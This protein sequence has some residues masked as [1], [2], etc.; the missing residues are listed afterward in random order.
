MIDFYHTFL[1]S[2]QPTTCPKCAART[3]FYNAI[4]PVSNDIVQV[5]ICFSPTCTFEFV[6]ELDHEFENQTDEDS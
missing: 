1:M 4:S 2:D 6:V 5:H 3:A